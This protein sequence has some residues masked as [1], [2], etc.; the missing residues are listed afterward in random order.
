MSIGLSYAGRETT[1]YIF[2]WMLCA[3]LAANVVVVFIAIKCIP[4]RREISLFGT[5]KP[6]QTGRSL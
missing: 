2:F 6:A 3:V 4:L 5:R 1:F